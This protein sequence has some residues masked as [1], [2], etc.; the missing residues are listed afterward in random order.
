MCNAPS[1][2][3]GLQEDDV[4]FKQKQREEAAKLKAARAVAGQ[5]GPMGELRHLSRPVSGR[6]LFPKLSAFEC[7]AVVLPTVCCSASP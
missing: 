3:C 2:T 1:V 6:S 4:K 5:K 7:T